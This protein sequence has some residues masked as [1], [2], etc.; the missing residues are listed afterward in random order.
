MPIGGG[1]LEEV[2]EIVVVDVGV[3]EFFAVAVHDAG[4]HLA[5]M[6]INSAVELCGGR[7]I[8]HGDHSLWGREAPVCAFGHA[9]R[10]NDTSLPCN[11]ANKKP[12]GL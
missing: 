11:N 8:L 7:V 1:E 5:G 10:C 6:E 9:G 4:V 3:D 12:R 2:V